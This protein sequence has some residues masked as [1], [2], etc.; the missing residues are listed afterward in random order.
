MAVITFH[1]KHYALRSAESVLDGLT[2]QGVVIPSSCRAGVCQTC[3]M[4]ATAGTPPAAAQKGLKPTQAQRGLFLA[5]ECVPQ[6]DLTVELPDASESRW[7]DASLV[8]KESL[9]QDIAR[10]VLRIAEPYEFRAGQYIN[11]LRVDGVTRSYSLA[12]LPSVDNTVELHVRRLPGGDMSS[13]WHDAACA[14][15]HIRISLPHGDCFYMADDLHR[16][17]L[18]A[19]TGSGLAPLCGVVQDALVAGHR[20]PIYLYHGS[21]TPDGLY[22]VDKFRR[23]AEAFDNFHYVPCVSGA[24]VE[25]FVQGRIDAVALQRHN[26]LSGHRVYL[27]GHPGLVAS[28]K[29][30]A[31]LA[32]AALK[33]IYADPFVAAKH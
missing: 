32:G 1:D 33:D 12:N 17:L 14:D 5:C 28:M 26:D 6:S 19:G 8:A 18:L 23:L 21:R 25:G 9:S 7:F 15:E 10:V 31:Y 27:C 3:L 24:P 20:G 22:F 11:V 30:E 16:P 29:R 4:R 13:W 2:R